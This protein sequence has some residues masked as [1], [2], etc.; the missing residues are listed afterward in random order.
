M[1]DTKCYVFDVGNVVWYFP[2]LRQ[3][4]M[5]SWGQILG[6]SGAEMYTKFVG[7]YQQLETNQL[8]LSDWTHSLGVDLKKFE[9]VLD[10][11]YTESNFNHHLISATINF[12]NLLKSKNIPH[13]YL[14]NAEEFFYPHIHRR[15]EHLFDFHVLSWE[16][17]VRKPDPQIY[18]EIF[19]HGP[20]QPHE[21]VFFD[22]TLSN[23]TA[24]KEL[25][26]NAVHFQDRPD[27][28]SKFPI[29]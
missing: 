5:D 28:Y 18:K 10:K 26:I 4:L 13:G 3:L 20:W 29:K 14:S 22:D 27:F 1:S 24:A 11:I 8:T 6:I 23:V 12:V 17:G 25:G 9:S 15:L 2:R 21:V 19:K 16:I 7:V